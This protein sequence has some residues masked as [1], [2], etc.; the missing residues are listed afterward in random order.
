VK[1]EQKPHNDRK[2]MHCNAFQGRVHS[3]SSLK[4]TQANDKHSFASTTTSFLGIY[5]G[6]FVC[7]WLF[8]PKLLWGP[9]S[10]DFQRRQPGQSGVLWF[11]LG[12]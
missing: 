5:C 2:F 12:V 8:K 10:N 9:S 1:V 11:H 4:M 7:H 3:E 6:L